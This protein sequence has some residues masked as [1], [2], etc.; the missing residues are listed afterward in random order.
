MSQKDLLARVGSFQEANT[1][2]GARELA[3]QL[4]TLEDNVSSMGSRLE[5]VKHERLTVKTREATNN[6][7][8]LSPGQSVGVVYSVATVQL[9]RPSASD[10]GKFCALCIGAGGAVALTLMAATGSKVNGAASI[11]LAA[12]GLVLLYCDGAN[13]WAVS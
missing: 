4:G 9:T 7:Q 11:A 13:Y 12:A 6:A 2:Q 3:R 8:T 5:L 1:P 10:A